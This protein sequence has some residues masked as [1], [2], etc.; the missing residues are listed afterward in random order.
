MSFVIPPYADKTPVYCVHPNIDRIYT[1]LNNHN[2]SQK[3]WYTYLEY[4][5]DNDHPLPL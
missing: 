4:I 5:S 2:C 3:D 1:E